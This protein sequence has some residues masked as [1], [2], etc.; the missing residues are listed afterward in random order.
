MEVLYGKVKRAHDVMV[1]ADEA[2]MLNDNVTSQ[3]KLVVVLNETLFRIQ[4]SHSLSHTHTHVLRCLCL[5]ID[6]A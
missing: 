3:L 1:K 2:G 6:I 4:V 5:A